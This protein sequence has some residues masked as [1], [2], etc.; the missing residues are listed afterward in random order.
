MVLPVSQLWISIQYLLF[1]LAMY[2]F[3]ETQDT[4]VMQLQVDLEQLFLLTQAGIF[5]LS[6]ELV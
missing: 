6:N 3:S 5:V 2:R 4:A 1:H